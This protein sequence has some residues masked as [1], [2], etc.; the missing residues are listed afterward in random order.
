MSWAD[1]GEGFVT[2]ETRCGESTIYI[3]EGDDMRAA[4]IGG[5]HV[6]EAGRNRIS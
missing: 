6:G 1:W 2:Y 5:I 4:S 3:E